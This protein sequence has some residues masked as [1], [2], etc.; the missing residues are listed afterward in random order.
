MAPTNSL[1]LETVRCSMW[2]E[3]TRFLTTDSYPQ[4]VYLKPTTIRGKS[5]HTAAGAPSSLLT[6]RPVPNKMFYRL[7]R[8]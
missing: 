1:G 5:R 2:A 3:I 4:K 6:G 7:R 8:V